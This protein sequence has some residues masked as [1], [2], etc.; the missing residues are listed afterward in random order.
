VVLASCSG[1]A[2]SDVWRGMW[3]ANG[4][5]THPARAHAPIAS[6]ATSWVVRMS[7]QTAELLLAH[8]TLSIGTT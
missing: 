4:F 5:K 7:R 1:R 3:M 6:R 8:G 2:N